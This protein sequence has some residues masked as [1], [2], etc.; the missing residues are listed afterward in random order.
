LG[1][2]NRCD[3]WDDD[4]TDAVYPTYVPAEGEVAIPSAAE[5]LPT[6]SAPSLELPSADGPVLQTPPARLPMTTKP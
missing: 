5:L 1:L 4:T 3:S 6:P 2:R